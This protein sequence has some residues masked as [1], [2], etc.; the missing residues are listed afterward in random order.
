[1]GDSYGGESRALV[2]CLHQPAVSELGMAKV[3]DVVLRYVSVGEQIV[4]HEV[5]LPIV[6]NVVTVEDAA[7]AEA[8]HVVVDE[9]LVLKTA[10]ARDEARRLADEG[11]F[12]GGRLVL[13]TT[14][15]ELRLSAPDSLKAAELLADGTRL[16]S[17]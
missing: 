5:T 12:E 2:F 11:D 6:V 16:P 1:M 17:K 4:A 10:Q 13:E 14:A 7:Q 9:V 8:D 15:A 3:A